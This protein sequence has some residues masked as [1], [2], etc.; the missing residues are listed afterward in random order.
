MKLKYFYIFVIVVLAG[1]GLWWWFRRK[2]SANPNINYQALNIWT[3]WTLRVPK[4]NYD[5][6]TAEI[7]AFQEYLGQPMTGIWS[8]SDENAA[9]IKFGLDDVPGNIV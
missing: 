2:K 7:S 5:A 3:P 1:G 9:F 8:E 6:A 4:G